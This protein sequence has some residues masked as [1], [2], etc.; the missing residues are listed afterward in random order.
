MTRPALALS[1]LLLAACAS[2]GASRG[3]PTTQPLSA[4]NARFFDDAVDYIENPEDLG[5]RLASDWRTQIDH[6][7]RESELIMPVRVETVSE[8]TEANSAAAYTL[9]A[10][11][12]GPAVKGQVP[13]DR[14]VSLRV[15]EGS[16]GFHTVRNNITRVQGAGVPALRAVSHRR[17]GAGA[18]ALAPLAQHPAAAG[19]RARRGGL[20]RPQRQ[21]ARHPVAAIV[22][23]SASTSPNCSR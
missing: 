22:V 9:T 13:R 20:Q 18:R 14:H 10:V 2:S 5:G 15:T 12:T 6:L 19:A 4:E 17:R 3:A 21:R 1:A 11:A 16:T 8:G 7:A 23:A